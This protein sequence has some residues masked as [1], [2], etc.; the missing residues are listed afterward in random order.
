MLIAGMEIRSIGEFDA[1]ALKAND[2]RLTCARFFLISGRYPH[3]I[4]TEQNTNPEFTQTSSNTRQ[5]SIVAAQLYTLRNAIGQ[6][7][8]AYNGHDVEWSD[9]GE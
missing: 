7:R 4:A 3:S 2:I 8:N 5:S 9:V 6:L 1:F